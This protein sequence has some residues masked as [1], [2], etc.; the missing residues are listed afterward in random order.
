MKPKLYLPVFFH[1]LGKKMSEEHT[2]VLEK[3]E[4]TPS[5]APLIFTLNEHKEGLYQSQ[6]ARKLYYNRAHMSRTLKELVEKEFLTQENINTYK[7]RYFITKKG[8]EVAKAIKQAGENVKNQVFSVLTEEE[9]N[10]FERIVKKM[11][12]NS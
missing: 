9:I 5:H 12:D 6:L 11:I 7:N 8:S 10:E 3:Y 2:K 4:L 1:H